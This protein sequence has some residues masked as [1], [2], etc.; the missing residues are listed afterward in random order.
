MPSNYTYVCVPCRWVSKQT[1]TCPT[2]KGSCVSKYKW[3]APRKNNDRAWKR[4]ENGE[5]L[6]DRRRVRRGRRG[7]A[8]ETVVKVQRRKV[9]VY[10]HP[11]DCDERFCNHFGP[12]VHWGMWKTEE[13][14]GT[15]RIVT[16]MRQRPKHIDMGG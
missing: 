5:W 14:P 12:N 8:P 11:E 2:C 3:S 1:A 6:W 15:R 10:P 7:V 4:I 16:N 9:Q 13:I